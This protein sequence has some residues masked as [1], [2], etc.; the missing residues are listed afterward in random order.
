MRFNLLQFA[1]QVRTSTDRTG[2]TNFFREK[3]ALFTDRGG[4]AARCLQKVIS[5]DRQE[6]KVC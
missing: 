2:C 4:Q 3:N 5:T 1:V 6:E